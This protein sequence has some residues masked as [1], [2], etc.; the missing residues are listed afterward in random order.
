[1]QPVVSLQ[2][3]WQVDQL[4]AFS[5]KLQDTTLSLERLTTIDSLPKENL[6]PNLNWSPP[7]GASI[8]AEDVSFR[9]FAGQSNILEDLNF[10]INVGSVFAIVG[11]SGSGKTTLLKLLIGFYKPYQGHLR[12][13][14]AALHDIPPADWRRHCGVVMQDGT[15]F[16]CSIKDNILAACPLNE[17]WLETVVD[18]SNCREFIRR[19]PNGLDTLVTEA[20]SPLSAG[21]RQRILIARALY[22][23]PRFLLLDEATSALDGQN[24]AVI[25]QNIRQLLP[26]STIVVVAHRLATVR[27][28]EHIIVLDGGSIRE[29][30]SHEEL[31]KANGLYSEIYFAGQ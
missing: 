17:A 31:L 24:E 5:N 4:L 20:A 1:L 2:L 15:L 8:N 26:N 12:L 16:D 28:A 29:R 19:L 11:P 6:T 13:G 25:V 27:T 30:G 14:D 21:Q 22:K 10:T 23:R 9:Y 7:V 3:Y 18:A